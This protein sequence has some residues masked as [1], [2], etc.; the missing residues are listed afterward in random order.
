MAERRLG[1]AREVE[2]EGLKW[3]S[4]AK[5]RGA[6]QAPEKVATQAEEGAS[7]SGGWRRVGQC[8]H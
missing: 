3:R 4:G 5:L 2:A 8:G 1:G 7:E 6:G